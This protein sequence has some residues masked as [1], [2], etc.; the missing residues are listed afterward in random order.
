MRKIRKKACSL[1]LMSS[2]FS[3]V[4]MATRQELG[5]PGLNALSLYT[6][7]SI[8]VN[9][10]EYKFRKVGLGSPTTIPLIL[11]NHSRGN[12]D[13]WDPELLNTLA[14]QRIVVTFNNKGVASSTGKTP[15]TF[16]SMADDAYNF[17]KAMGYKKIDVLGFSIG[18]CVAQE[19]LVHHPEIIRKA[20]LAGTAPKGA[21]SINQRNPKIVE[22]VT[23]PS[24]GMDGFLKLFFTPSA[25][26][27][28]LGKEFWQRR[29]HNGY[30]PDSPV[31][32]AS[33]ASQAIAR[34]R[35]GSDKLD[36]ATYHAINTPVLIAN[37]K[38]DIMM[39]T[40]NSITLFKLLPN[41]QLNLYP[42]SGHGFLFQNPKIVGTDFVRFLE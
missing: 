9:G 2:L 4:S 32:R 33:A 18:G 19:L 7:D 13:S 26:S 10:V 11:L 16:E 27:Q 24:L 41:A 5:N 14:K 42:D 36:T 37:G 28:K 29:S 8:S 39:P 15:E 6:T 20:I 35:W 31:N 25:Q 3:M 1:L 38:D 30:V 34:S 12:L 23:A 21:E 40:E 17:I 22:I